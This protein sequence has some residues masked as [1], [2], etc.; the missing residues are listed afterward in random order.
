VPIWPSTVPA[1][2]PGPEVETTAAGGSL[3]AGQPW[4]QVR[5]VSRPTLTVYSP[6]GKNTG[7]AVAEGR[8]AF[9]RRRTTF[10]ITAW[11]QLV[12]TWLQ[13]IGMISP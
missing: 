4:L 1:G 13:T 12:E 7:A 10:P 11:P 9:G 3:V 8:H 6:K 5:N 2:Q